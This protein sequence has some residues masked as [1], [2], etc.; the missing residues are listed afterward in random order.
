VQEGFNTLEEVM[1][2]VPE[3]LRDGGQ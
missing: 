1:A 2:R 3:R